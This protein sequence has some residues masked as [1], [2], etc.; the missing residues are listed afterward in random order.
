MWQQ[1]FP[2]LTFDLD[3]AKSRNDDWNDFMETVE[4]D[5]GSRSNEQSVE[6]N[7]SES[8]A[9]Q[10]I[11]VAQ[12]DQLLAN[13]NFDENSVWS[14]QIMDADEIIENVS[15]TVSWEQLDE[16]MCTTFNISQKELFKI[17]KELE[18]KRK[19]KQNLKEWRKLRVLCPVK[20]CSKWMTNGSLTSHVKNIHGHE[21]CLNRNLFVQNANGDFILKRDMKRQK[22]TKQRK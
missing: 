6:S 16:I 2:T 18:R 8:F 15:S 14:N 20:E 19:R 4:N 13:L 9:F 5:L 12:V 10:D 7:N 11:N 22:K 21:I 1:E 3:Y 17:V